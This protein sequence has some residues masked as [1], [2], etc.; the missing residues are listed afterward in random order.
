MTPWYETLFITIFGAL[1]GASSSYFYTKKLR[2][3]DLNYKK[4]LILLETMSI[5]KDSLLKDIYVYWSQG[6]ENCVEA[7]CTKL[8]YDKR[9]IL[10]HNLNSK[11]SECLQLIHI[12]TNDY[13]NETSKV[14]LEKIIKNKTFKMIAVITGGDFHSKQRAP[15]K[16]RI[17]DSRDNLNT[18]YFSLIRYL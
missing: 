15:D 7:D 14:K 17:K 4:K 11:T 6:N 8:D 2:E 12:Y 1:V 3:S 18:I 16:S 10:E 5:L 9:D 13:I